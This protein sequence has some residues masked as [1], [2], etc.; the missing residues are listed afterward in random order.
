M[1]PL[2][3]GEFNSLKVGGDLN[4]G[5]LFELFNST[6]NLSRFSRFVAKALY[7]LLCFSNFTLLFFVALLKED[8]LLLPL[9]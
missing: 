6:L 5:D 1:G 4:N 2:W 7:K 3:K 8:Q 9:N